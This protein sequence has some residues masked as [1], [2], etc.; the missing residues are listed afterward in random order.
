M[1]NLRM[2]Q[3]FST[4]GKFLRLQSQLAS[5]LLKTNSSHISKSVLYHTGHS[6]TQAFARSRPAWVSWGVRV[7]LSYTRCAHKKLMYLDYKTVVF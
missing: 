2:I 3:R 7:S 1:K 6:I 5:S 4:S